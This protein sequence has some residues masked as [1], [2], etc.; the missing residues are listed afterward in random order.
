LCDAFPIIL[1]AGYR[2]NLARMLFGAFKWSECCCIH[3]LLFRATR[4]CFRCK[5]LFGLPQ[6][7]NH[8]R[9]VFLHYSHVASNPATCNGRWRMLSCSRPYSYSI[10]CAHRM[11][12]ILGGFG[13]LAMSLAVESQ[14]GTCARK[15]N[16]QYMYE[17]ALVF[18]KLVFVSST[19]P[20]PS[21]NHQCSYLAPMASVLSPRKSLY[22]V[23]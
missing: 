14:V 9:T 17:R 22:T 2:S 3:R 16:V 12:H 5:I 19:K 20:T 11:S 10:P 23:D 7:L 4:Q 13:R 18:D 8:V 21:A 15:A 1:L 6:T